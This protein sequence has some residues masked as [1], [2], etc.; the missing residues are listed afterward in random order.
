MAVLIASGKA[1]PIIPASNSASPALTLRDSGADVG[2]QL[3]PVDHQL[4]QADLVL[5]GDWLSTVDV[6]EPLATK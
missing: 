2:H 5:V 6:R 4:S 1:D 3:L